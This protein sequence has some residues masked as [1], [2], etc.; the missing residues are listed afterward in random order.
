M[1][2]ECISVDDYVKWVH[3]LDMPE[4]VGQVKE[5]DLDNHL[6]YIKL[7]ERTVVTI[8]AP[9]I[10]KLTDAEIMEYKLTGDVKRR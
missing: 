8:I 1:P 2:G 5:I 10:Q 6:I 7:R 3:Y 4:L 9:N